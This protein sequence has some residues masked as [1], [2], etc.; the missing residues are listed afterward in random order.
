MQLHTAR[1]ERLPP[2]P[3]GVGD[4]F[5]RIGYKLDEAL[6]D[7]IDNSIDAGAPHVLVRFIRTS[8]RIVRIVIADDGRGMIEKDL[9]AAM[10]YGVRSD[11]K[12]GDL[13][14]YGIG[15]KSASFSQAKQVTVLS[16]QRGASAGRRWTTESVRDDWRLQVID[17]I[18]AAALLDGD[19]GPADLSRSGTLVIWDDLEYQRVLPRTFEK[20]H[21]KTISDL[22]VDLGLRFHRFIESGRTRIF[23][24]T[25]SDTVQAGTAITE[26]EP[27]DPFGYSR[28]G[29][30]GYPV[31][32]DLDLGDNRS[33]QAVA[34]IWP[35][36]SREPNYVLGGGK[37]A[38]YQGFYFYR[39]DRLISAG[40]WHGI[41]GDAE[42]HSS[43]ARVSVDV[44]SSLDS[45]F[46]L[47]VQKDDFLVP[48]VFMDSLREARAGNT[49]FQEYLEAAE[50]VYRDAPKRKR[51]VVVPADGLPVTLARKVRVILGD[52][53]SNSPVT[54]V[55]FV[56]EELSGDVFLDVD[57]ESHTIFLNSLYRNNVTNGS[58]SKADA[59]L[60]KLALFFAL[61]DI[62]N[63]GRLS[64]SLKADLVAISD[65]FVAACGGPQ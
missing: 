65:S 28:T 26:M 22:C 13:G 25:T 64:A 36:K 55:V 35:P 24:D 51:R 39:N 7:I 40:G 59:P 18:D 48:Q 62:V 16:R 3:G 15:L 52:V 58:N 50:E 4:V 47:T 29:R 21:A 57:R 34:H 61:R 11:H 49:S 60:F 23:I 12:S 2:D 38:Q 41:R 37:V 56:W 10:Q 44:P 9:H 63:A 17:R 46:R 27:L 19:W 20:V 42:P 1:V 43:L 31:T 8:D 14:K 6:A 30:R 54:Q 33:L 45:L 32:L 53:D 5:R